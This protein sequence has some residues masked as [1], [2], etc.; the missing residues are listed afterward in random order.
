MLLTLASGKGGV[1]KTTSAI[2][3]A[4]ALRELGLDPVLLDLDSGGDATWSLGFE[5]AD[6]A[7]DV[8]HG[9]RSIAEAAVE[10]AEG[11]RVLPASPGLVRLEESPV[12][13]IAK[14]LRELAKRELVIV[15]TPPG[16]APAVTRAAIAAA[17]VVVVPFVAEP[18]AERRARH[19]LD[20]ATV[21][22]VEPT[23]F[24][25]AVM[26]DARR[27]LTR[28]VLDEAC[29]GGLDPIALVP[30][31]VVVPES[32]NAAQSIIAHAPNSPASNAYRMAARRLYSELRKSERSK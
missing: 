26:V 31:A 18:T 8:L 17:N 9:R 10:S 4:A 22:E 2:A 30:R 13:E 12:S 5:Q 24:G 7:L 23:I 25:L 32:A 16:F 14:R 3:L 15:D 6:A 21:L 29:E 19:V 20:I 27:A 1:G 11:L 28:A